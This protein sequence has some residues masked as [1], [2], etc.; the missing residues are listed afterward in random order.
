[1]EEASVVRRIVPITQRELVAIFLSPI[2]YIIIAV[3]LV[4][5]GF[6]FWVILDFF[7]QPGTEGSPFAIFLGS[8][9]IFAWIFLL[10]TA[11][12]IT[13][14]LF[15]EERRS[16]T[17]EILFTA[18]VTETEVVLGKFLAA[19]VFY[20]CLWLPTILYAVIL[21]KFSSPDWRPMATGYL[22]VALLG[23]MFVAVGEFTSAL[24]RNQIVAYMTGAA[25]LLGLFLGGLLLPFLIKGARAPEILG[26]FNLYEHVRDFARGVVD[27][28]QVV[29]YVS[30][31]VFSLFLATR[32]IESSKWR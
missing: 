13:M 31:T 18:P 5:N 19:Y 24:T 15:A 22:G 11:P 8:G 12:A 16:G 26:Y 2:A 9:N 20:L 1:V 32:V 14:R 21:A 6:I 7:K 23:A 25:A 3:F 28:R 30:V 17:I 27:S 4:L 10:L 29:Y